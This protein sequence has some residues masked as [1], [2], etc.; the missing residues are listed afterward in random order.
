MTQGFGGLRLQPLTG[1]FQKCEVAVFPD[2]WLRVWPRTGGCIWVSA[3]TGL[4]VT[5]KEGVV[6]IGGCPRCVFL[7]HVPK[8]THCPVWFTADGAGW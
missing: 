3:C 6:V 1:C 7:R 2:F 4:G 5:V 8:L